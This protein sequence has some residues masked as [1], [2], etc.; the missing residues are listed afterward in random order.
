MTSE[1][2]QHYGSVEEWES[3]SQPFLLGPTTTKQRRRSRR[4][5][6]SYPP[7]T[8]TAADAT[9]SASASTATIE[10][11]QRPVLQTILSKRVS[12]RKNYNEKVSAIPFSLQASAAPA[13]ATTT[14][15]T[16]VA[17][18]A[19][20]ATTR[21]RSNDRVRQKKSFIYTMLNPRSIAWQ[22]ITFKWFITFVIAMDVIAYIVSTEPNLTIQQR[23][24][25][26]SWEAV[27]SS[28][29]LIEYVLR[30]WTV[31]ESYKYGTKGWCMGRF[32]YAITSPAIIDLVATL[33][34]FV[35]WYTGWKLP[36]LTY[37][38]AFRLLRILKTQGFTDATKSVCRVL[39]YNS[40][41]LIVSVWIGLGLVLFTAVLMYNFRPNSHGEIAD[42]PQFESLSATMY[43]ATLMLTGQGGPDGELPWYTR[44]VVL[45]TGI[46]SIGM[47]AIPASML[48]WGFEGEAARLAKHRL[49]MRT[50]GQQLGRTADTT[51]NT[52]YEVVEDDGS[53]DG[54]SY[55]S[56]DYSTDDEYLKTIAGG[57]DSGNGEDDGTERLKHDFQI[58]DVD[59]SGTISLSEYIKLSR[60]MTEKNGS[61]QANIENASKGEV[62]E[63][64]TGRLHE[65]E[66]KVEAN[67]EKL[68]RIVALL[69]ALNSKQI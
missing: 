57:V 22:A 3:D 56:N 5:T 65:L 40:E 15:P 61:V 45:V 13:A 2:Q 33:P 41:I 17:T 48:T 35:E 51:T 32:Q 7:A 25:S 66:K 23:G 14:T 26:T 27:T 54:W 16:A 39:Y 10:Q 6:W 44:L 67:S 69:E 63:L 62:P 38:R 1:Q 24:L 20:A 29:F 53:H 55:S 11:Q 52:T 8:T 64:M 21:S 12:R 43:L 46:F 9:S 34:Y 4:R 19:A 58:A 49:M 59:R 30:L 68:D 36:T 47:F 42:H 31:T 50:T 28:I 18:T 60:E 37:I